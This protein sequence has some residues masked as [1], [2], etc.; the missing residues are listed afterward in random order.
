MININFSSLIG[1][2]IGGILDL[3]PLILIILGINIIFKKESLN[4]ILWLLFLLVLVVYSLFVIQDD[5]LSRPFNIVD[6]GFN[7]SIGEEIV[8]MDMDDSVEKGRLHLDIGATNFQVNFTDDYLIN[9]VQDGSFDYRTDNKEGIE[10]IFLSNESN[11]LKRNTSR[12]F[13]IDLNKDIPWDFHMDIGAGSG[14]LNLQEIR[15]EEIDLDMGAGNLEI[16]FGDKGEKIF[17]DVDAGASKIRFKIPKDVGLKI[18][19]QGGLNS[20]NFDDLALIN[21]GNGS[22]ISEDFN[23]STTKFE[24]DL[25]MGVGSFYIDLY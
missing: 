7:N 5:N 18:D 2:I 6:Q 20:T 24:I 3:W 23:S 22:Y 12:R 10:N 4:S 17:I 11:F 13:Q 25:D 14:E 8:T 1:Q 21:L 15:V 16:F 9:L 19:Y